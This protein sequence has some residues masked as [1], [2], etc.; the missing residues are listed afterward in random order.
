MSKDEWIREGYEEDA[1]M[2]KNIFSDTDLFLVLMYYRE[3]KTEKPQL[4]ELTRKDKFNELPREIADEFDEILAHVLKDEETMNGMVAEGNRL[5][6]TNGLNLDFL[7]NDRMLE[8]ALK[9]VTREV[10]LREGR[11]EYSREVAGE[12]AKKYLPKAIEFFDAFL[13]R[14]LGM[15][16]EDVFSRC[17]YHKLQFGEAHVLEPK[18]YKIKKVDERLRAVSYMRGE[19]APPFNLTLK[20]SAVDKSKLDNEEKKGSDS[21][22]G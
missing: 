7:L 8:K 5:M 10:Y 20:Y 2:E 22:F 9:F 1:E 21:M 18:L 6:A 12:M 4:P 14:T 11:G 13:H 19:Y 3:F 17:A 15:A 16:M